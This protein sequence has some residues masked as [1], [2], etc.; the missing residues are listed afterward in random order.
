MR[1]PASIRKHPIHPMLVTI[2]IGLWVF[3]LV[4]DLIGLRSPH[5]DTWFLLALY[6]ILGGIVGALLAAI[7]GLIDLLSLRDPGHRRI[8]LAHMV[9][10][11]LIVALY[12]WNVWLRINH[13]TESGGRA[14]AVSVLAIAML[15]V[16]GWLGGALVHVHGVSVDN[17]GTPQERSR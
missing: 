8:A 16:S 1:T 11:L 4:C 2:P 5:P 3:S 14:L 15:G 6:T 13:P 10:N 12:V 17:A 9:L 7:P